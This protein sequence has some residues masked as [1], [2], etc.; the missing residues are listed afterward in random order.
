MDMSEEI[1]IEKASERL[2]FTSEI[3][4]EKYRV[5]L[6]NGEIDIDLS[7]RL[8]T[9]T[10]YNKPYLEVEFKKQYVNGIAIGW[11]LVEILY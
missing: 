2:S 9:P 3:E 11:Q 10:Q 6:Y 5:V 8:D 1:I 4:H 7:I